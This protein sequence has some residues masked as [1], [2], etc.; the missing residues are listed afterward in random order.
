MH[1]HDRFALPVLLEINLHAIGIE[2]SHRS[3]LL[4][5]AAIIE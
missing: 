2:I 5:L 1:Q 3:T 4:Y